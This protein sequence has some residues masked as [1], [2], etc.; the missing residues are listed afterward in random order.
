MATGARQE[1]EREREKKKEYL[2]KRER[3]SERR[4]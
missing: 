4:S 3:S 2:T 1:I